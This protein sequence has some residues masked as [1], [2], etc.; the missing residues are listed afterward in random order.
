MQSGFRLQGALINFFTDYLP[1]PCLWVRLDAPLESYAL[2]PIPPRTNPIYFESEFGRLADRWRYNKKNM[3]ARGPLKPVAG[4]YLGM[5]DLFVPIPGSGT[6][7]QGTILFG[8]FHGAVPTRSELW[9]RWCKLRGAPTRDDANDFQAFARTLLEVPVLERAVLQRLGKVL[10]AVGSFLGG[11]SDAAPALAALEQA[12]REVF[13]RQ[14]P[15]RMWH[16]AEARRDRFNRGPFQGAELAPWDATEFKLKRSPDSAVAL[17]LRDVVADPVEAMCQ[18]ARLQWACFDFCRQG[19]GLVAGRLGNEGA[20]I[21]SVGT[22]TQARELAL[23][24]SQALSRS[25]GQR[26]VAAYRSQPRQAVLV[27]R[28]IQECEVALRLGLARGQ[29]LLEAQPI[30]SARDLGLS[31]DALSQRL[32]SGLA[33]GRREAL[34]LLREDLCTEALKVSGGRVDILRVHLRWS[35]APALR[36]FGRRQDTAAQNSL[37]QEIDRSLLAAGTA[38]EL[39]RAFAVLC[40][41]LALR[42]EAPAQGDVQARLRRAAGQLVARP[43]EVASLAELA[44]ASG[45]S[46][47]HFSRLFKTST[48]LGFAKSRLEARVAKARGLLGSS[49]I[50]I[51]AVAG[52]CGFKNSAHFS[53]VFRRYEGETPRQ[54]RNK[55][56]KET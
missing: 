23:K 49:S 26:V 55:K 20:L 50:S 24:A 43:E 56:R 11:H 47:A 28:T 9:T 3:H 25:L 29:E 33:Q 36:S 39:L 1:L 15:W 44:R 42:F 18:A 35:L 51:T 8:S 6:K 31:M 41:E 2:G 10:M 54:F 14:L 38:T 7:H 52:E 34:R 5:H 4:T 27:D 40:D 21:L 30:G 13:G 32:A 37:L 45:L 53:T 46:T 17:V 16:Y 48:G 19:A 22:R 12:K